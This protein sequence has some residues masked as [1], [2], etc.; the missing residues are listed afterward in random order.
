[1]LTTAFRPQQAT[2]ELRTRQDMREMHESAIGGRRGWL[3]VLVITL[4]LGLGYAS[5]A[6]TVL[7]QWSS[8]ASTP[9]GALILVGAACVAVLTW[10][11]GGVLR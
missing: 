4:I 9:V 11:L 3:G 6:I 5:L 2:R 7:S 8:V 10:L 1:M